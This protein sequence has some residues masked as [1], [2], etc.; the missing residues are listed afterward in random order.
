MYSTDIW[1]AW[2]TIIHS[3]DNEQKMERIEGGEKRMF[4]YFMMTILVALFDQGRVS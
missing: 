2:S 4:L 1:N 3:R